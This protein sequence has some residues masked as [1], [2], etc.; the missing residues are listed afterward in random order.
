MKAG[1][2]NPKW[3]ALGGQEV[4]PRGPDSTPRESKGGTWQ[5]PEYSPP[6]VGVVRS[7]TEGRFELLLSE[8]LVISQKIS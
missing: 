5:N 3:A 8:Y 7:G 6:P 4:P 2:D 1:V